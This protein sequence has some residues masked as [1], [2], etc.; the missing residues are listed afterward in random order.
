[1]ENSAAFFLGGDFS[2]YPYAK[3]KRYVVVAAPLTRRVCTHL[4]SSSS[5]SRHL[6]SQRVK[7]EGWAADPGLGDLNAAQAAADMGLRVLVPE[8]AP[9]V[10]SVVSFTDG[11]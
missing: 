5:S 1:M 4:S 6:E 8:V 9:E 3:P 7:R 11:P 10:R 2:L